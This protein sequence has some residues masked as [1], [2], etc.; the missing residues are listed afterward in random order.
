MGEKLLTGRR[1]VQENKKMNNIILDPCIKVRTGIPFPNMF[2][3]NKRKYFTNTK[4]LGLIKE[5]N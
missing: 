2:N 1:V 3:A 5:H 4:Y